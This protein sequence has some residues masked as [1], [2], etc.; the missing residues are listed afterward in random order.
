MSGSE[1]KSEKPSAKRLREAREKGQVVKSQDVAHGL[2]LAVI[3]AYFTWQ[4]PWLLQSLAGMIEITLQVLNQ[5][6]DIAAAQITGAFATLLMTILVQLGGTLIGVTVLAT[7]LQTGGPL[8]APDS[9]RPK[10]D[11]LN[12]LETVKNWFSLKNLFSFAKAILQ[13]ALLGTVFGYILERY[14][15]SLRFLAVSPIQNGLVVA[16][17]LASWLWGALLAASVLFAIVDY[18]V[19]RYSTMKQ[20][21]M[22][23]D[24]V[25][26][27]YKDS[28]GNPEIKHKRRELHR[29]VQSGSLASNVGRSSVVVRNPT[30]LAVCLYYKKGETALP[31]VLEKGAD[32]RAQHI[33]RLAERAHVPVVQNVAVARALMSEVAVGDMI[34]ES[35]F[36]PVAALLRE[37]L[38]VAYE[39]DDE[40]EIDDSE[41]DGHV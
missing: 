18:A 9:V 34:P 6:V 26:R 38:N 20:L 28:E 16:G 1:E 40:E 7:W 19:Q 17:T 23:K 3:F 29:E 31:M 25:K 24:E 36:E 33:V 5:P 8:F 27:E 41:T 10:L 30:H 39:E 12:P 22:S 2:Q 15:G 11:K 14:S 32:A 13:V 4:G 37:V 21:R 35:L